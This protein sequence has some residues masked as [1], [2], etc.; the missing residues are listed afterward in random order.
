V[1]VEAPA[2]GISRR[3]AWICLAVLAAQFLVLGLTQAWQDSL[4]YDEPITMAAGWTGLERRDLRI[5]FEH[6]PL[7]KLLAAVP[8][9][10]MNPLPLA[11]HDANW[12]RAAA[13][14]LALGLLVHEPMQQGITFRFRLVPTGIALGVGLLLYALGGALFGRAEGLL[15]AFLWFSAPLAVGFGHLDG[16]DVPAAASVLLVLLA[17]VHHLRRP[18]G[19]RLLCLGLCL[20]V[21]LLTRAGVG[22][23]VLG[24]VFVTVAIAPPYTR[25]RSIL[26]A[27]GV[28]VVAW[29]VVWSAYLLLEPGG[30]HPAALS[31]LPDH[32]SSSLLAQVALF[33]PW[34]T[35]FD[36]GIRFLSA[37]HGQSPAPGYLFGRSFLGTPWWFWLGSLVL[38]LTP[39]TLLAIPA[40]ALRLILGPKERV[41]RAGLALGPVALGLVA[42]LLMAQRPYG[43][44]YMIPLVA[45]LLVLAGPVV[46]LVRG[47]LSRGLLVLAVVL[48]MAGLWASHPHSLAQTSPLFPQAWRWGAD[49]NVDWG[50]DFHYLSAWAQDKRAPWIS[51]FGFGPSF[52]LSEIPGAVSAHPRSVWGPFRP[53]PADTEWVVVSASNLNAYA[54]QDLAWLRDY[55]PVDQLGASLLVYRFERLPEQHAASTPVRGL[56]SPLCRDQDYSVQR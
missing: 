35:G 28:A 27:L 29:L 34:P 43:I 24:A 1:T 38:G 15:S 37:F 47:R 25:G 9:A 21:A 55:C 26:G 14:D 11:Q 13:Q 54:A 52:E 56:P 51:Y 16:L 4:T 48:Q 39:V 50:Q 44:R 2:S 36:A 8:V 20:G 7:P 31:Q 40:G 3:L 5:N 49:S 53:P 22:M 46:G 42:L 12:E 45:V 32:G 10:S 23:A 41:W 30:L 6:P 17:L 33:V 18:G 19:V